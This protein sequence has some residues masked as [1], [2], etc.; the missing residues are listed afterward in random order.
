M[1][2]CPPALATTTLS[3]PLERR[4]L[5]E[6]VLRPLVWG[7]NQL[8]DAGPCL[9]K[10]FGFA[11]APD[12]FSKPDYSGSLRFSTG[13]LST[14]LLNPFGALLISLPFNPAKLFDLCLRETYR[15]FHF[16]RPIGS[17]PISSRYLVHH[18]SFFNVYP[19]AP[20]SCLEVRNDRP[21]PEQLGPSIPR[22]DTLH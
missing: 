14:S 13:S 10:F 19:I 16:L 8:F 6:S 21:P 15:S 17:A 3:P 11:L 2:C 12:S 18:P 1:P 4:K 7:R 20:C 9:Q 5:A 22:E